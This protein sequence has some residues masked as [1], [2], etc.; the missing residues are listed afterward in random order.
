MKPHFFRSIPCSAFLF[1]LIF[2]ALADAPS[3]SK[4]MHERPAPA[5]RTESA[6]DKPVFIDSER[7]QGRHEYEIEA[8]GEPELRSGPIR[9]ADRMNRRQKTG[10]D[11]LESETSVPDNAPAGMQLKPTENYTLSA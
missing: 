5:S 4:N 8:R 6:N 10:D 1:C 7:I 11:G 9:S 2:N 3:A